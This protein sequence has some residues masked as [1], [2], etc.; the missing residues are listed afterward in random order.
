[1]S[2][3]RFTNSDPSSFT[4]AVAGDPL[5][6]DPLDPETHS[7]FDNSDATHAS[8]DLDLG[9]THRRLSDLVQGYDWSAD[10]KNLL[11]HKPQ[12]PQPL[13]QPSTFSFLP[14]QP[15]TPLPYLSESALGDT[16]LSTLQDAHD[17]L[18]EALPSSVQHS[19]HSK[20]HAPKRITAGKAR[21]NLGGGPKTRPAFVLKLW[22]MVNDKSNDKYIEWLPDGQSFRVVNREQFEKV[23]LP[24]YF[25]HSNFS[26]FV[27]QLNMYGWHKVQDVT[28]G[29]MQSGEEMWQ[30][31]SPNFVRGREDLLDNIVRNKGSKGS[32]DEEDDFSKLFDELELIKANQ[33]SIANDLNRIRKDNDLLWRECYQS[34]ERH[35]AHSEAFE[36]I[37]RFL[38]TLYTSNQNKFVSSGPNMA[39]AAGGKQQL[40]LLPNE[41]AATP[42]TVSE[43]PSGFHAVSEDPSGFHTLSASN[44]ISNASPHSTFRHRISSISSTDDARP[45]VSEPETPASNAMSP[46]HSGTIPQPTS[47]PQLSSTSSGTIPQLSNTSSGTIPQLSSTSSSTIPPQLSSALATLGSYPPAPPHPATQSL[48]SLSRDLD[49]QGESLQLVEDWVHKLVPEYDGSL[50]GDDN[51]SLPNHLDTLDTLNT[52]PEHLPDHLNTL[53]D[54]LPTLSGQ[55]DAGPTGVPAIDLTRPEPDPFDVADFLNSNDLLDDM[56]PKR[57]RLE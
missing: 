29:A 39:P 36:K 28:A 20:R 13:R 49:M 51:S 1:M 31:K 46:L 15:E 26:S 14:P 42:Q 38:A 47:L 37:L 56:P 9:T 22:N 30:F 2:T 57:R 34:R 7:F 12:P 18:P 19:T 55:P 41:H 52:L 24:K 6:H 50:P 3:D 43:D 53:P 33:R 40:L 45:A 32:D 48:D 4:N 21:R 8:T 11:N 23:V 5:L 25:K 17:T 27:R 10:W 54:H 35:K 16:P 44:Q